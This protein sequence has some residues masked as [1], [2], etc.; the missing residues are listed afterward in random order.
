MKNDKTKEETSMKKFFCAL[1]AIV[2]VLALLAG[3]GSQAQ[4][5]GSE[6][7]TGGATTGGS[8][9][10]SSASAGGSSGGSSAPAGGTAGGDA[11]SQPEELVYEGPAV[12]YTVNY[13]S[14]EQQNPIYIAC[15]NRITER[16][17]GKVTFINY[18]SGSLFGANDTMEQLGAGTADFSDVTL[19][20][21]KD[22]FPYTQQVLSYPFLPFTSMA[23]AADIINRVVFSNDLMLDEFHQ[24][25]IH[26]IIFNAVWGTTLALAK[27]VSVS[28]PDSV[29]GLKLGTDDPNLSRF[30]N[31]VGATPAFVIP[32]DYYSSITSGVVDGV[33][34]GMNVINIFG[35]LEPSKHVYMFENSASTSAR[36]IAANLKVWNDMDPTLQKIFIEEL[37]GEQYWA[38]SIKYWTES[39]QKHLDDAAGWGIPVDYITGADMKAW[40]DGLKPYGDEML[41]TLRDRGCT[42]VDNVLKVWQDAIANYDGAY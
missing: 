35:G 1:L 33:I 16:T 31:D 5:G 13:T 27:D 26:P 11:P 15:F 12:E 42:E 3:C 20:N 22:Q 29:K 34:N 21:F 9:G 36:C 14:S 37:T 7:A 30:L 18:Y 23:Q 6:T 24:V 2:M 28:N 39:D 38:D 10:G 8:T 25:D 41:Q 17:G 19:T 40:V 32:P 4:S